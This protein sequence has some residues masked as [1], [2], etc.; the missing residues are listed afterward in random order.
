MADDLGRSRTIQSV[1]DEIVARCGSVD[2]YFVRMTGTPFIKIGK[3]GSG[4]FPDRLKHLQTSSPVELKMEALLTNMDVRFERELHEMFGVLRERG[5]WFRYEDPLTDLVNHLKTLD[6]SEAR[7]RK[8]KA[9]EKACNRAREA[10]CKTKRY[11]ELLASGG[12][13]DMRRA[14]DS[15]CRWAPPDLPS[16]SVLPRWREQ[17]RASRNGEQLQCP[18][19]YLG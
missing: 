13:E 14:L 6:L 17:A 19:G 11:R 2:I 7:A 4:K 1:I 3:C 9:Q 8:T 18:A 5:E 16:P 12:L 15:I 10:E